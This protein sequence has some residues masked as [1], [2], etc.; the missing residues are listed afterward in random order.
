MIDLGAFDYRISK[1]L[2]NCRSFLD[3]SVIYL[4]V[5]IFVLKMMSLEEQILFKIKLSYI[6]LTIKKL[7][8]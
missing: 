1:F 7:K 8:S 3:W 2:L 6:D 5:T 4:Y